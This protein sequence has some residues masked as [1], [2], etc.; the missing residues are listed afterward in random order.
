[1][2]NIPATQKTEAKLLLFAK[3]PEDNFKRGRI[4]VITWGLIDI[5]MKMIDRLD[6][7]LWTPVATL[8]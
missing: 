3:S 8:Q 1:M 7:L 5:V 2:P 4:S 6:T